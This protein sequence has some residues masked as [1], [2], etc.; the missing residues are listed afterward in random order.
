MTTPD[1]IDHVCGGCG[2][3]E[4]TRPYRPC[5]GIEGEMFQARFCDRCKRDAEWR[6][7]ET[8][9]C[10]ILCRTRANSIK[11]P[12]YPSEWI[13]DDVPSIH[14]N[15][16][17]TAFDSVVPAVDPRQMDMFADAAPDVGPA[18]GDIFT[19]DEFRQSERE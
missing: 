11:D 15:P 10:T 13:E 19:M 2:M 12:D 5:N 17:C 14:T 16:R 6:E 9:P 8:N 4:C 18:L 1:L 3:N 7:H